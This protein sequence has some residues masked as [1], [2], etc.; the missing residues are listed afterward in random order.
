M[1]SN[2]NNAVGTNGAFGGRTSVDA[3]NDGLA[4][5]SAGIMSGWACEPSS[6]LTVVL[7]GDGNTRD[8]AIAEDN[9]GNKTTIN[10]I[11]GSPISVT[12]GNAPNTNSRIDSIVAYVDNP[13]TGSSTATDNYGACGLIVV[14]G[15]V[16]STPVPPNESTIR[17]A[18]TADGASG[19][20]AYYVVLANVTIA[21]GTTDID[22]TMIQ[23]GNNSAIGA[24]SIDF[25]TITGG[26]MPVATYALHIPYFPT[27]VS[28]QI[29]RIGNTVVAT[30][31]VVASS[32]AIFDS[33]SVVETMPSGFRPISGTVGIIT[34]NA[35]VGIS[36]S[37]AMIIKPNGSITWS[38]RA[39]V[40]GSTRFNGSGT[41]ITKDA[42][43]TA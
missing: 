6:G 23:A 43:P 4:S 5:Y 41:W 7:G 40:T 22:S 21:N 12:V 30:A 35:V 33:V 3:F 24:N 25:T 42:F 1:S 17:T 37:A 28:T 31:D 36:D 26:D 16:A 20:T 32:L 18:I 13:P 27:G 11:S 29:R 38:N 8:V 9:A 14:P 15:T 10:N 2:P 19:T 39:D 34:L